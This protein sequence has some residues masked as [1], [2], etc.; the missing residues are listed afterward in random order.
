LLSGLLDLGNFGRLLGVTVH[1]LVHHR[2]EQ[3]G[4]SDETLAALAGFCGLLALVGGGPGRI[5]REGVSGVAAAP[6]KSA[7]V[8]RWE[9]IR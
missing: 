3:I 9:P 2:V 8:W 7:C 4:K 5:R 1:A 6:T